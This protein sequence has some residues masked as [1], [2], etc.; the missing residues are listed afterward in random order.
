M[1]MKN[2]AALVAMVVFMVVMAQSVTTIT[3]DETIEVSGGENT[4]RVCPATI[5]PCKTDSECSPCICNLQ[6][7][8]CI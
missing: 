2:K 1:E 6:S 3:A 8:S 4:A 7:G 5:L